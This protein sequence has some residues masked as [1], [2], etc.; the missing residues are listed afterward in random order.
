MK[1]LFQLVVFVL[2]CYGV[3]TAQD[4]PYIVYS[5]DGR[6][7]VIRFDADLN[8]HSHTFQDRNSVVNLTVSTQEG[9]YE[10]LLR[11]HNI[12]TPPVTYDM[13]QR[14]VVMSDPH[15]DFVPFVTTLQGSGVIDAQLDWSFGQDHLVVLGDVSDR[16]DDVTAIY[17][18]IYKLEEQARQV[19]GVVHFLLGN[20]EV[21]IAQNDLRYITSKYGTIAQKTGVGY[22][23]LWS[24]QTELGRWIHAHNQIETIGDILFVHAGVSPQIAETNL[25]IGQINDTVRKYILLERNAVAQ[26]PE[27][28]LVMGSTGTLWYRGLIN[29]DENMNATVL[30]GILERFGVQK[31]IVGHTMLEDVSEFFDGKVINVNVNNKKNMERGASRGILIGPDGIWAIDGSGNRLD[32]ARP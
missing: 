20:H 29:R 12:A 17:W 2:C 23:S 18:F 19:G 5:G 6:A 32:F 3:A 21:M 8:I 13:P 9:G 31:I 15:G 22:G 10:F 14:I 4:G 7:Q 30:N 11:L 1:Q 25:H 28:A 27:A 26:S 24:A 16:G